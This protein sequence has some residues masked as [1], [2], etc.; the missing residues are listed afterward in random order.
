MSLSLV[1]DISDVSTVVISGVGHDLG[2]TVGEGHAVFTVDNTFGVLGFR[3]VEAGARVVILDSVLVGERLRGQL[4]FFVVGGGVVRSGGVGG[5]GGSVGGGTI[6][7]GC[8]ESGSQESERND[9]LKRLNSKL[10][11]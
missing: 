3:L 8:G 11:F 1:F 2:T 6:G 5:G 9:G 4:L 7:S 10:V